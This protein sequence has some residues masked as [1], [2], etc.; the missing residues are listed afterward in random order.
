[1]GY[2]QYQSDHILFVKNSVIG[3]R[4]ILIV[5]VDD[6]ILTGDHNEEISK[7][8]DFLAKEFEVKDVGILRYFLGMKIARYKKGISI[9]QRMYILNLLKETDMLSCKPAGTPMESNVKLGLKTN[10]K[11]VDKERYQ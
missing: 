8:K 5:Y 9:S 1:M 7:L 3:K 11:P 6:I 2:T 10:D 4:V